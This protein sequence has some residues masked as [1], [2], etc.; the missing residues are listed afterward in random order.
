MPLGAL[1]LAR[2]LSVLGYG[3]SVWTTEVVGQKY[4][5][6]RTQVP[7]SHPTVRFRSLNFHPRSRT[8]QVMDSVEETDPYLFNIRSQANA[9]HQ[10]TRHSVNE[11]PVRGKSES[12][13]CQ[14]VVPFSQTVMSTWVGGKDRAG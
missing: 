9:I 12:I 8:L 4:F 13:H 6:S 14:N 2:R 10:F 7:R 3:Y 1:R 5:G 11:Y